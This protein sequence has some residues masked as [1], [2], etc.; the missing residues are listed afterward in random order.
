MTNCAKTLNVFEI[1]INFIICKYLL[2]IYEIHELCRYNPFALRVKEPWI[3][4]MSTYS[5]RINDIWHSISDNRHASLSRTLQ[6]TRVMNREVVSFFISLERNLKL[7]VLPLIRFYLK[8]LLIM[9]SDMFK[10]INT[11]YFFHF[12]RTAAVWERCRYF[13]KIHFIKYIFTT[14]KLKV[15]M[16]S[17]P[18]QIL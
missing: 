13:Y 9:H 1:N 18:W 4:L 12:L 6:P 11:Q 2:Y 8:N 3:Y 15:E 17:S 5:Y 7:T 10:S 14:S 16:F